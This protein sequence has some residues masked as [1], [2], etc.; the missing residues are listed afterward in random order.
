MATISDEISA[1][2]ASF[3]GASQAY[4]GRASG[5][6]ADDLSMTQSR[7]Q[8][9]ADAAPRFARGGDFSRGMF[10]THPGEIVM[11]SQTPGRVLNARETQQLLGGSGLSGELVS[12][13]KGLIAQV[14]NQTMVLQKELA[15]SRED[16]AGLQKQLARVTAA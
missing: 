7:L 4:A 14:G 13:L 10:V 3:L 2:V 15:K 16:N 8:Q 6:Y 1:A 5:L 9:L 12:L 11:T